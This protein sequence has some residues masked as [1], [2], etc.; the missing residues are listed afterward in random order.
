MEQISGY[1]RHVQARVGS[2]ERREEGMGMGMAM[3][4]CEAEDLKTLIGED[5]GDGH[6]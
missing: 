1:D 6:G 5:R 2:T 4:L 3:R